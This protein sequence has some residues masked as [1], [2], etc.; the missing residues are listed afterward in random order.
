MVVVL[1]ALFAWL[2]IRVMMS[3]LARSN[4]TIF[5]I[6]RLGLGILLL[7]GLQLELIATV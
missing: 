3:W 6:Y 2:A 5:V 4:F 1:S 7:L